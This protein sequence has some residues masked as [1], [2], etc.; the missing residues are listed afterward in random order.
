VLVCQ[1]HNLQSP[2]DFIYVDHWSIIYLFPVFLD[3]GNPTS[4]IYRFESDNFI[5]MGEHQTSIINGKLS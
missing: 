2:S 4:F 5:F 3:F 1:F